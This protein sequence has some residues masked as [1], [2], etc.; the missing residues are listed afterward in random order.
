MN[1]ATLLQLFSFHTVLLIS[2]LNCLKKKT[3]EQL[4]V[5]MKS[6]SHSITGWLFL[7]SSVYTPCTWYQTW[8]DCLKNN[9]QTQLAVTIHLGSRNMNQRT[10]PQVF[11]LNSLQL[12]LRENCLEKNTQ[13]RLRARQECMRTSR[14][15][16]F[17]QKNKTT[18]GFKITFMDVTYPS[19]RPELPSLS[20]HF[21]LLL[22]SLDLE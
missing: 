9:T 7:S 2:G 13:A 16:D 22:I 18:A 20:R 11:I 12:I 21:L 3:Q 6:E 19:Q 10:F 5:T 15:T 17:R 8:T 4:T 14:R 1:K